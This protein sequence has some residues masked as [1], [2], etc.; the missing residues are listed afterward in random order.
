ML[1]FF[2]VV[3]SIP[4]MAPGQNSKRFNLPKTK[5]M[6]LET[7]S[8]RSQIQTEGGQLVNINSLALPQMLMIQW[9][10]RGA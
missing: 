8:D 5:Q 3:S 9:A 10:W 7:F 1:V 2:T 6:K 4:R